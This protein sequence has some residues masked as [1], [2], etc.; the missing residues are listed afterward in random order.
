MDTSQDW[1]DDQFEALLQPTENDFLK[2]LEWTTNH[3]VEIEPETY[4]ELKSMYWSDYLN[5]LMFSFKAKHD[6]GVF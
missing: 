1:I 6:M 3:A 5:D 2:W 4:D